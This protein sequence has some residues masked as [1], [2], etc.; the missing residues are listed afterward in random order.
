MLNRGSASKREAQDETSRLQQQIAALERDIAQGGSR[1]WVCANDPKDKSLTKIIIV[2]YADGVVECMQRELAEKRAR[3][4][5]LQRGDDPDKDPHFRE[6]HRANRIITLQKVASPGPIPDWLRDDARVRLE[7]L[8][9][10]EDEPPPCKPPTAQVIPIDPVRDHTLAIQRETGLDYEKAN[11]QRLYRD[12]YCLP[13]ADRV[14]CQAIE[15]VLGKTI[16]ERA[17]G[18]NQPQPAP[19][20]APGQPP[21]APISATPHRWLDST[22]I[23]PRDFAYG[24]CIVRRYVSGIVSM[25]GVGKTSE[26]QVEAVAMV[27]GRDL[28]GVK[29]KRPY[30]VWYINLEDPRD[31]IDRRLAAIFKHYKISQADLG[32]RLF[33]DSGRERKFVIAREERN[34]LIFDQ[35]VIADINKTIA[36]NEIEVIIIDPFVNSIEVAENDNTKM[37]QVISKWADIAEQHNCAVVIVYHVRKGSGQNSYNVEDMRGAVALINSC[38]SVRVLNSMTKAEGEKAGVERHRSYFRIDGGK[39]NLTPPPEAARFC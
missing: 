33:T 17:L 10:G 39:S 37:A 4:D 19:K 20:P 15:Q 12:N 24:D 34:G 30:R 21:H 13:E 35:N 2:P 29:P 26:I 9:R 14:Q 16:A 18:I 31:E 25:G 3:F 32:D 22:A 5:A 7:A 23:L 28:L 8:Q 36:D 11:R 27:T 6:I 38:R 1:N